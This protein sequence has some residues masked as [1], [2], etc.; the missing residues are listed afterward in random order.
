MQNCLKTALFLLANRRQLLVSKI[1]PIVCKLMR[2]QPNLQLDQWAVSW[3]VYGSKL[4]F[5]VFLNTAWCSC[6]KIMVPC[7]VK[8]TLRDVVTSWPVRC[9]QDVLYFRLQ[10]DC[11]QTNMWR[12][13]LS[14]KLFVSTCYPSN[15]N[16]STWLMFSEL[17]DTELSPKT[18]AVFCKKHSGGKRSNRRQQ[19]VVLIWMFLSCTLAYTFGS[20]SEARRKKAQCSGC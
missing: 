13:T 8:Q 10:T 6:N 16:M 18:S 7:R 2:K 3:W 15:C 14:H 20:V 11:P 19:D 12:Q 17:L 5:L 1:S 4:Q 9:K